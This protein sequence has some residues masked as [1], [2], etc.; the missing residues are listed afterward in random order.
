MIGGSDRWRRRLDGLEAGLETQAAGLEDP[1]DPRN[2]GIERR[3]RDLTHL[4]AFALPLLEALEALPRRATWG[5]WGTQLARLA[6]RAIR[7]PARVLAVL[8]ELAPM[9]PIGPV[10]LTEVT[11]VLSSR[12]SEMVSPPSGAPAGKLYVASITEA[13]GLSFDIVFV[14]GLAEKVFPKKVIEDPI[15]PDRVRGALSS[16]LATAESRVGEERLALR[17]AIGAAERRVVLSYPRL[18]TE[19]GRPRVPSFY[20]LE[21]LRAIEGTLPSFEE[22]AS[23]AEEAGAAR[24]AWPAPERPEDAIDGAEYDLAVLHDLLHQRRWDE[25]RGEARYLMHAN[26]HLARALRS[27][28]ARW[29]EKWSRADGMVNPSEAAKTLLQAHRPSARPYSATA[30]EQLAACPY[31]FYLRSV[32]RLEPR[33][34]P[35]AIEELDPRERGSLIHEAQARVLG[36]LRDAAMLPLEETRLP[37]AQAMLREVI[38]EIAGAYEERLA[39]AIDRVWRDAVDDVQ[40]DLSE[41][42]IRMADQPEWTPTAF[43]LAFGLKQKE[44]RDRASTDAPAEL[45]EGLTLRGAIDLVE[46]KDGQLRATDHKTGAH[47]ANPTLIAGGRVLQPVLYARVLEALFPEQRVVGGRL[48]YCTARGRYETR[49]V[50]LNDGARRAVKLLATTL[51]HHVANAFLPAAPAE[52]ECR[53]CDYRAVCGPAEERRVRRKH[54]RGLGPLETLRKQP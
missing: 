15:V 31:R 6:E 14:P 20:A 8:R 41:W 23:R 1:D 28:F 45:N 48:Y 12:L 18:D 13:R 32:V 5:E 10:G 36:R 22:L 50:P 38:G 42:L 21:V 25:I 44:G 34:V 37:E 7:K 19:R 16:E 54:K 39:P 53:R 51:D 33:E 9:G 4:R 35:E 27:R 30:L 29:G 17:L 49:F 11:L 46:Q 47:V 43:E 3:R 52:G 2:R 24:M 26:P 40:R